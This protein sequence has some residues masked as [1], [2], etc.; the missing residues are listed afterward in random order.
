[1]EP[2]IIFLIPSRGRPQEL[3][4]CVNA[5]AANADVPFHILVA[6]DDDALSHSHFRPR[7]YVTTLLLRPRHYFVRA[8]NRLFAEG[9]S[10]FD[11]PHFVVCNDDDYFVRYGWMSEVRAMYADFFPEEDGL[12]ELFA[13]GRVHTYLVH[14]KVYEQRDGIMYDPRYTQYCSD[15]ALLIDM[16]KAN[17]YVFIGPSG[18]SR[19]G[20]IVRHN[21]FSTLDPTG[22]ETWEAWHASDQAL[23]DMEYK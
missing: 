18:D 6:F 10:R 14:R 3:E 21:R 16:Q 13:N 4:A 7:P 1:V 19:R 8:M 17:R 11:A 23:F 20:D 12:A 9:Y 2:E 5:I 15:D 22:L